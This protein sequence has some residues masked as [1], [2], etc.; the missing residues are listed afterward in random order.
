MIIV[1]SRQQTPA[2]QVENPA[3]VGIERRAGRIDAGR[4]DG[5]VIRYLRVVDESPPE[6]TFPGSLSEKLLVIT[7]DRLNDS[8]KRPRNILR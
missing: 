6:R 7:P 8:R 2:N 3:F 1:P 5:V 4:N